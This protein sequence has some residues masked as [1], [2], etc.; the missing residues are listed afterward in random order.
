MQKTINTDNLKIGMYV[1]LPVSWYQHPFVKNEFLIRSREQIEKISESGITEVI[2]DTK[3]SNFNGEQ[4]SSAPQTEC[5][6][7]ARPP[8]SRTIVPDGLREAIHDVNLAPQEKAKAVRAHSIT[9]ISNLLENPTAENIR[10]VK[11][12]IAEVVDLILTDDDTSLYLLDITSHD[13]YTYTHSVNVG[14]L[15]VSLSKALFRKS[16]AHNMHELGAG[17]FLHDLGKVEVDASIINKPGKLTDEEMDRM[18][19]HP[20]MGYKLSLRD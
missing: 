15:A 8:A 1:I 9:M 5:E 4:K 14:F 3:K 7:T 11:K 18:R 16:A 12:S 17:F 20:H 10:D 6:L 13:F 2:L 19:Q